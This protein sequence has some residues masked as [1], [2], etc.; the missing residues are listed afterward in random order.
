MIRFV[1]DYIFSSLANTVITPIPVHRH[2]RSS[3]SEPPQEFELVTESDEQK[4]DPNL[5]TWDGPKDLTNPHNW[6]TGRKLLI[7]A[8]WIYGS[9][10]TTIASSI[11]SSGAGRIE[12]EFHVSSTVA[13][14]GV[15]IYL[16]VWN[17]ELAT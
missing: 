9:M 15:S 8:I 12:K 2:P 1:N 17:P 7:T 13:T 11:F 3:T 16:L 14:L 4:V 5:V 6:S 10:V